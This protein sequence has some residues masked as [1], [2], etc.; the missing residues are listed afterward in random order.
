MNRI[1]K[2]GMDVHTANYTLCIFEP[3]FEHDGS[4]YYVTQ[5]KAEAKNIIR[6]IETLKRKHEDDKLSIVCGYK[7]GYFILLTKRKRE[8][9]MLF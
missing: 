8:L 6:V 1:I 2:I 5:V 3:S 7:A 4:V 9:T